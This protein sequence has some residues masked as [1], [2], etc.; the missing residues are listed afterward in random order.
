MPLTPPR[1][2]SVTMRWKAPASIF[3]MAY[4]AVPMTAG[5]QKEVARAFVTFLGGPVGRPLFE[6]AG[7]E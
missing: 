7:I 6:S 2:R 3:W 1:L 5:S 4:T